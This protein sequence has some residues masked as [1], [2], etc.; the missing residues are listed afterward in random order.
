M[1]VYTHVQSTKVHAL[2]EYFVVVAKRSK[3]NKYRERMARSLSLQHLHGEGVQVA[4][5]DSRGAWIA[6]DRK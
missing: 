2:A 3:A 6:S 4:A 5:L 1:R